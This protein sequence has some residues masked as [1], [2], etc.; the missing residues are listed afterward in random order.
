LLLDSRDFVWARAGGSPIF[1]SS[2]VLDAFAQ[3]W[4]GPWR[5]EPQSQDLRVAEAVP[6]VAVLIAPLLV[7]AGISGESSPTPERWSLVFVRSKS[8]WRIVSIIA[9]RP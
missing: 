4:Q 2:E 3:A 6:G 9:S 5:L 8:G 1:G 7:T